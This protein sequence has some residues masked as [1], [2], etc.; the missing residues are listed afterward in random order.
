MRKRSAETITKYFRFL[1]T[2]YAFR[3]KHEVNITELAE[4]SKITRTIKT[5]LTSLGYVNGNGQ[6]IG[7]S[8]PTP[9]IAERVLKHISMVSKKKDEKTIIGKEET[10]YKYLAALFQIMHKYKQ[11]NN[12]AI[13]T[14]MKELELPSG[15][16]RALID[17]G[18]LVESGGSYQWLTI[19]H[20]DLEMVA[21]IKEWLNAERTVKY[22]RT[23]TAIFPNMLNELILINK[24]LDIIISIWEK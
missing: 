10:T 12:Y 15:F 11:L 20:P 17:L 23:S 6:W 3:H 18:Y 1:Q 21:K 13:T 8:A 7:V 9:E 19:N 22:D 4:K 14:L 5:Y 2:L 16:N 24:K